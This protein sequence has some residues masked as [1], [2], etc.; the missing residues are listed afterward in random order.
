MFFFV[1]FKDTKAGR[2]CRVTSITDITHK[3]QWYFY[4]VQD[5]G[6]DVCGAGT[7]YYHL[8]NP[9]LHH[10]SKLRLGQVYKSRY[11]QK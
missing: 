10:E 1:I 5:V 2:A 3:T 7:L 4:T 8:H 6:E 11:Y 9:P